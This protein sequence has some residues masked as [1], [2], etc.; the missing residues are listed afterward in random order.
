MSN[1]IVKDNESL[2]KMCIRDRQHTD[3]IRSMNVKNMQMAD[4]RVGVQ[5]DMDDSYYCLLYTSRCV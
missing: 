2:D 5:V 4:G 3:T 1:V